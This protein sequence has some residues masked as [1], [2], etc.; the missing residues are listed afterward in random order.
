MSQQIPSAG[1]RLRNGDFHRSHISR[2]FTEGLRVYS[3]DS[4][5]AGS[6]SKGAGAGVE[7]RRKSGYQGRGCVKMREG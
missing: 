2:D 4:R 1:G 7:D 5:Q 3:G 6:K